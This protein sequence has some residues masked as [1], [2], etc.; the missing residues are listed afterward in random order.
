MARAF[1]IRD[2]GLS[3]RMRQ[4]QAGVFAE[5]VVVLEAQQRAIDLRPG[6]RLTNLAIDAGGAQARALIERA[7]AEVTV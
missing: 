5:D 3:D 6:A 4:A 7:A 1:D 2:A